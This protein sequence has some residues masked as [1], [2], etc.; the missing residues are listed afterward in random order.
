MTTGRAGLLKIEFPAHT[1]HL[2]DGGFLVYEGDTYTATDS[3]VGTIASIDGL[4]EGQTG[5]IPALDITFN[6]PASATLTTFSSGALQRA[7]VRLWL[8][9]FDVETGLVIG[10]PDLQFLGQLDQPLASIGRGSF[11]VSVTCVSKAEWI[12]ERDIGNAMS[13]TFHKDIYPGETGHDNATG[14]AVPAA[15]GVESPDSN[16]LNG[17]ASRSGGPESD[18]RLIKEY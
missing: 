12:F 1:V 15:W 4:D 11:T 13:A 2:T 8:A 10:T 5:S 16:S 17:G 3:L 18:P 7:T 9:E 6:A 14:L